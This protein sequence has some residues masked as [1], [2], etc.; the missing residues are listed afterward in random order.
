ML[1]PLYTT[2]RATPLVLKDMFDGFRRPVI[3][4]ET[5][6]SLPPAPLPATEILLTTAV[7]SNDAIPDEKSWGK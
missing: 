6:N 4:G 2:G 7:P 1:T 5:T 3:N